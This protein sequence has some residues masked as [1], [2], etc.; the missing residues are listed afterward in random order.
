[1]KNWM[2]L[3]R[4]QCRRDNEDE[5]RVYAKAY[6]ANRRKEKQEQKEIQRRISTPNETPFISVYHGGD[7]APRVSSLVSSDF[8]PRDFQTG[9]LL[10]PGSMYPLDGPRREL[11]LAPEPATDRVTHRAY[12][13]LHLLSRVLRALHRREF[14]K[15]PRRGKRYPLQFR[16]TFESEA[17]FQ[18]TSFANYGESVPV[19]VR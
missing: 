4:R 16:S 9:P 17:C 10:I 6:L 13:E 1:M 8:P 15:P 5:S 11:T 18:S 12:R 7:E 2:K 3:C 14:A 19:K